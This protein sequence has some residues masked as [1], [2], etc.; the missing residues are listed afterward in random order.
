MRPKDWC[1]CPVLPPNFRMIFEVL[2]VQRNEAFRPLCFYEAVWCSWQVLFMLDAVLNTYRMFSTLHGLMRMAIG[3]RPA[4]WRRLIA[5]PDTSSMQCLPCRGHMQSDN[6][7]LTTCPLLPSILSSINLL[8][9][10]VGDLFDRLNAGSVQM[11]VVLSRLNE[12]VFLNL[13]FHELS[14]GH[15]VVVSAVN[16]VV[17]SWPCCVW[18]SEVYKHVKYFHEFMTKLHQRKREMKHRRRYFRYRRYV[19]ADYL[20]SKITILMFELLQLWL[21]IFNTDS[22]IEMI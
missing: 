11:V 1:C 8:P 10:L 2:S 20:W 18:G 9:H 7:S 13:S 4:S 22:F 19:A 17:S 6:Q 14:G 3:W 15:E 5:F 12:L 21:N 16:F